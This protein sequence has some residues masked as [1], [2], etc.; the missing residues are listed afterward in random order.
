MKQR[1]AASRAF[2]V[3]GG[4]GPNSRRKPDFLSVSPSVDSFT[5][6]VLS[7]M[8]VTRVQ[9]SPHS[10]R[11]EVERR[12]DGSVAAR[13]QQTRD[14]SGRVGLHTPWLLNEREFEVVLDLQWPRR[15]LGDGLGGG[16]DAPEPAKD[17][18]V[19]ESSTGSCRSA[20]ECARMSTEV[21]DGGGRSGWRCR[22]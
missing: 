13:G 14:S 3:E 4:G 17:A 5:E 18:E 11:R 9:S 7:R 1:D 15:S 19:A 21:A 6:L 22:I 2:V 8:I 20:S 12:R 16:D 10:S